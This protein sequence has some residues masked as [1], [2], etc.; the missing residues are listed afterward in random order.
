MKTDIENYIASLDKSRNTRESYHRDLTQ[1][2]DFLAAH[3]DSIP[4]DY[5]EDL[6]SR[7][8]PATVVRVLA[9][10]NGFFRY[11]MSLGRMQT[12]PLEG[13]RP[14]QIPPKEKRIFTFTETP[15]GYSAKAVRDRAM[16]ALQQETGL[17]ATAILTMT[18]EELKNL[19]LT[20]ETRD[21]LDDYIYG[22]RDEILKGNKTEI[23]FPNLGGAPMS[24][25]GYWKIMKQYGT[26]KTPATNYGEQHA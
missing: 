4:A 5:I 19:P 1:L 7:K 13:I 6:K 22:S 9:S 25:Q 17:K 20:S 2:R 26:Y 11:E 18:L 15:R 8:S 16:I 21:I 10:L 23:L 12:N 24:R 14:P 3:P